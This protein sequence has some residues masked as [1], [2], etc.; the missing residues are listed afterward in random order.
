M[1]G[2]M[3]YDYVSA[4]IRWWKRHRHQITGL[5]TVAGVWGLR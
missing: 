2:P 3:V 4:G 1:I 5:V